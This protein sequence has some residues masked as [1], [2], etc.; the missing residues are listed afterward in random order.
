M[1]KANK[2]R[3]EFEAETLRDRHRQSLKNE[4]LSTFN[5]QLNAKNA[6]LRDKI[7]QLENLLKAYAEKKYNFIEELKCKN[8]EAL[9]EKVVIIIFT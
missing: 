8:E 4:E 2:K 1:K 9:R 5:E 3:E 7:L 6:T